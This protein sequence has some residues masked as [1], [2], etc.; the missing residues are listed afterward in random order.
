MNRTKAQK[1]YLIG[2]FQNKMF[3]ND[4]KFSIQ[5]RKFYLKQTEPL[6]CACIS[7]LTYFTNI[8]TFI[9]LRNFILFL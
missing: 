3:Q 2:I 4:L 5:K 6:I 7:K 9:S 1:R 8:T